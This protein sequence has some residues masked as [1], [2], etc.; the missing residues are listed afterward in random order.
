MSRSSVR[1]RQVAPIL[2]VMHNSLFSETQN[3]NL[4]SLPF[5]QSMIEKARELSTNLGSINNSILKGGGNEAGY[6]GEL[7]LQEY[8]GADHVSCE[9]GR[10]KYNRDLVFKAKNFEVKTK[11]RTK[12]PIDTNYIKY[13]ASINESSMH[14]TPDY[15]AFI[16]ITY[17]KMYKENGFR[18]YENPLKVWFCGYIDIKSFYSKSKF[19]AKGYID[20]TNK[21]VCKANKRNI[22]YKDLIN[23][24]LILQ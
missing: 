20:P 18:F 10:A 13:E 15:Y 8:L 5:N 21:N 1:F 19:I 16:S 22:Y 4:V 23:P 3:S 14:Q 11:R 9:H 6:L 7:A 17:G 24:N 2:N 12:D